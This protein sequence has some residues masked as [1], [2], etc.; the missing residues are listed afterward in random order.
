MI[1]DKDIGGGGGGGGGGGAIVQ[2]PP[3]C[4]SPLPRSYLKLAF[5]SWQ[6]YILLF[7]IVSPLLSLYMH[8]EGIE[9]PLSRVK[10]LNSN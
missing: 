3:A 8:K 2:G 9:L 6:P 7:Y 1:L 10:R 5:E 4:T